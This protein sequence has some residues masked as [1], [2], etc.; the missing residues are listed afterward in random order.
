LDLEKEG[1]EEEESISGGPEK[2][3]HQLV[4][5]YSRGTIESGFLSSGGKKEGEFQRV[6]KGAVLG[7][8][9]LPKS[10]GEGKRK[11]NFVYKRHWAIA[12]RFKGGKKGEKTYGEKGGKGEKGEGGEG[13][14]KRVFQTKGGVANLNLFRRKGFCTEGKD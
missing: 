2:K 6:Q 13:R 1:T 4:C 14:K 3:Q 12:A 5:S 11:G 10:M 8:G 9:G 7:R